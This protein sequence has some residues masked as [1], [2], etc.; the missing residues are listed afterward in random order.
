MQYVYMAIHRHVR[1][2]NKTKYIVGKYTTI[3]DLKY[4]S[5]FVK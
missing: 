3:N 2:F 5:T 1:F 4:F